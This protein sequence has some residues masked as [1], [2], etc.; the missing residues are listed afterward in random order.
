MATIWLAC[1]PD[2]PLEPVEEDPYAQFWRETC[3]GTRPHRETS[4]PPRCGDTIDIYVDCD[5]D[6]YGSAVAFPQRFRTDGC[7]VLLPQGYVGAADDCDDSDASVQVRRYEDRDEDGYRANPVCVSAAEVPS[8]FP[9]PDDCDDRDPE[10]H[11]NRAEQWLDGIDSDCDGRE[12]PDQ[13][14]DRGP[15]YPPPEPSC[16][17]ER[18]REAEPPSVDVLCTEGPDL[19]FAD[20]V[21]CDVEGCWDTVFVRLGNQGALAADPPIEVRMTT[22]DGVEHVQVVTV[23]LAP[24]AR[25]RW[26]TMAATAAYALG[27][28]NLQS[29]ELVWSGMECDVSNNRAEVLVRLNCTIP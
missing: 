28:P 2:A 1:S 18:F 20:V 15:G 27:G 21:A 24:G 13:G 22:P 7:T 14:C 3:G 10:R 17:C 26:I 5:G 11:P 19:M 16:A 6:G 29:I 9:G 12:D 23:P 25:S 8:P 4:S